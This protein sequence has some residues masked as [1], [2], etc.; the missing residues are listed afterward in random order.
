MGSGR[1]QTWRGPARQGGG[2]HASLAASVCKEVEA[3]IWH[4]LCTC[5]WLCVVG[6]DA[7]LHAAW[8]GDEHDEHACEAVKRKR[9]VAASYKAAVVP[10]H[11]G[12][13]GDVGIDCEVACACQREE[14]SPAVVHKS[15]VN[16]E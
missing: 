13:A 9:V 1:D 7:A 15:L 8:S 5:S 4:D 2:P 14:V 12:I 11:G 16:V 10:K 6:H 3:A